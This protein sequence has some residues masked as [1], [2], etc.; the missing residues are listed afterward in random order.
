MSGTVTVAGL[1]DAGMGGLKESLARF[2]KHHQE[3][4][5]AL[6]NISGIGTATGEPV[7]KDEPRPAYEH[8]PWP[9]MV[10]HQDGREVIVN[11]RGELADSVKRGFREEP[12]VKAKVAVGDPAAEKQ[13]LIERNTELEGKLNAQ[14]DMLSKLMARLEALEQK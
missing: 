5:A 13:A 10:Y 2:H 8:Q 4:G 11:G 3:V 12:Y 6:L 14:N 1:S 9:R 7:D